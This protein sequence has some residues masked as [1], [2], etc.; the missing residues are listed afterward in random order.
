[1]NLYAERSIY[2]APD[3]VKMEE[4]LASIR[5]GKRDLLVILLAYYA[6]LSGGEMQ[7]VKVSD[8]SDDFSFLIAPDRRKVP[9]A[10]R[11][12]E[13]M[14]RLSE[15][16]QSPDTPVL[17]SRRRGEKV[18]RVYLSNITKKFMEFAGRPDVRLSDL[19]I[20]CVLN[21]M[22][23][24]PWEYVSQISGLE[25]RVLTQRY[26]HYLPE[27]SVRPQAIPVNHAEIT[28]DL[29]KSIF[30]KHKD[31]LFGLVLRLQVVHQLSGSVICSLTWDMVDDEKNVIL[32][33]EKT[34]P[35]TDDLRTCLN[36]ARAYSDTKWVLAYPNSKTPYTADTI[37]HLMSKT[38]L[39]DGYAG[40][41][42]QTLMR[43]AEFL[44]YKAI[45]DNLLMKAN[46][47][48]VE[49]FVTASGLTAYR[50]R[51]ILIEM[52][53]EGLINQIG[54]RVYSAEKTVHPTQFGEV[55]QMLTE[56]YGGYFKSAQFAEAIGIDG[57]SAATQLRRMIAE[58]QVE[59]VS[60]TK[61][62][63]TPKT[64]QT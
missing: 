42:V 12:A 56:T 24:Y 11:L 58:G 64:E 23:Q 14:K 40:I 4:A 63:Y 15:L 44:K 21:W 61:Y 31:D 28:P 8:I 37:S 52:E 43:A 27:G 62:A 53:E 16:N 13:E 9:L 26:Q 32:L 38:L 25:L 54:L 34:I 6:G 46:S 49:D 47:F 55:A 19:R 57:R 18:S 2:H 10:P 50:A 36:A 51:M 59:R 29:I 48:F 39:A 41:T 22:Q 17:L 5:M 30:Q 45:V 1:M 3:P 20:A 60:T 7:E 33:P 35:I